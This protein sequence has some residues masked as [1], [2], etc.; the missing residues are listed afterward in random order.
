MTGYRAYIVGQD[1]HFIS[2]TELEC[3]DDEAALK[4]AKQLVNGHDVEIW[5][6]PRF[7]ARLDVGGGISDA[8]EPAAPPGDGGPAV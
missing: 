3:A 8:P 6:G 2:A 4:Y 1:G 5:S 7:I